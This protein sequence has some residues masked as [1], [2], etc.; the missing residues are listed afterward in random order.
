VEGDIG[1]VWKVL[2]NDPKFELVVGEY[3]G[4]IKESDSEL[5]V[6]EIGKY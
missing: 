2:R 5:D 6:S 1:E 4:V 3:G